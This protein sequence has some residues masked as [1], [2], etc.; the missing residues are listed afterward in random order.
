MPIESGTVHLFPCEDLLC[1]QV[2]GVDTLTFLQAQLSQD[3]MLM[4]QPRAALSAYCTP[5]GRTI[6]T[7][8]LV[9]G[10]NPDQVFMLLAGDLAEPML[11]RL[12]MFV[13]RSKVTITE[14]EDLQVRAL[15]IAG[16]ALP[17]T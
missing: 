10:E 8:I 6:A 11:R 17:D 7:Q 5:R 9:P 12:R 13:L 2:E 15:A 1:V 16:T 14:R 3:V 4:T